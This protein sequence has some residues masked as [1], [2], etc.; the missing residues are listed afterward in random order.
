MATEIERKY[1]VNGNEWRE[2]AGKGLLCRQGYLSL[3]KERVVRIRRIGEAAYLTIK[4]LRQGI[5]CPEYEYAIP[6]ED[7]E[8]ML[9]NTCIKPLIEKIRY[10]VKYKGLVWEIDEFAGDNLGLI[11]AEVELESESQTVYLPPWVGEEVSNDRRYAN[12]A[13]VVCPYIKW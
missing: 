11:I 4:G 8:E 5:A 10:E 7:A 12:A 6:V 13:L 3:D 9:E 1:L 2:G